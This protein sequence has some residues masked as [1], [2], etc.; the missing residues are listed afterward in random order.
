MLRTT[1]SHPE[2]ILDPAGRPHMHCARCKMQV[3]WPTAFSAADKADFAAL[4]RSDPV[5]AMRYLEEVHGHGARE[6]KVLVLHIPAKPGICI[7]C[8]QPVSAGEST[9]TCRSVSLNW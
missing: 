6:S 4:R 9:C 1:P 7:K 3:I 5:Q 2:L 8:S